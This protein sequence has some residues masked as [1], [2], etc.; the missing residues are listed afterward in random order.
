MCGLL[1]VA[2]ASQNYHF[3]PIFHWKQCCSWWG[4]NNMKSTKGIYALHTHKINY[5]N[6]RIQTIS[7]RC[8][9][10]RLLAA[11]IEINHVNGPKHIGA[12]PAGIISIKA[13][14][15]YDVESSSRVD[16]CGTHHDGTERAI[17]FETIYT[18][19]PS[20]LTKLVPHPSP[21]V[22]RFPNPA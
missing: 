20:R 8:R 22:I 3:V 13:D 6:H 9:L 18:K 21:C 17:R 4:K 10:R 5:W 7:Y 16:S 11:S 14:F 1:P 15:A 2:T 12:R 19:L